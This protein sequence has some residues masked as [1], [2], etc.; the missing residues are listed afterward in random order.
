MQQALHYNSAK[1]W[2]VNEMHRDLNDPFEYEVVLSFAGEDR[3]VV[4]QPE[5]MLGS[6]MR[7]PVVKRRAEIKQYDSSAK[8]SGADREV[9]TTALR[10]G[11][12]ENR[13]HHNR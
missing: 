7:E 3:A 1:E 12:D 8:H 2:K 6:F 10:R 13:Q 4:E 11:N 9:N 5:N